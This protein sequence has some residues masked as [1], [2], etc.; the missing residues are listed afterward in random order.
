MQSQNIEYT[1]TFDRDFIENLF[2]GN[3]SVEVEAHLLYEHM[4][5]DLKSK[6]ANQEFLSSI[7]EKKLKVFEEKKE[8]EL[9]LVKNSQNAAI[10]E[11]Q[12]TI[13]LLT[14]K[15]NELTNRIAFLSEQFISTSTPNDNDNL[16]IEN[17][18]LKDKNKFLTNTCDLLKKSVND[19]AQEIYSL[20]GQSKEKQRTI[21]ELS[22]QVEDVRVAN[23][24]L[25]KLVD[26]YKK[27][28]AS[29]TAIYE[30]KIKTAESLVSDKLNTELVVL[31]Q[32]SKQAINEKDTQLKS[33]T[34]KYEKLTRQIVVYEKEIKATKA[35][36]A[37]VKSN[38]LES[39]S[40]LQKYKRNVLTLEDEV[41]TLRK[42]MRYLM[43]VM[44]SMRNKSYLSSEYGH[45][46]IYN[47]M[48][49]CTK[50]VEDETDKID[51]NY[52]LGLWVSRQGYACLVGV[53]RHIDENGER[54]LIMPTLTTNDQELDE[55]II[56]VISAIQ[57]PNEYSKQ[58]LDLL[59]TNTIAD[60]DKAMA[61]QHEKFEKMAVAGNALENNI[62]DD[63]DL[64]VSNHLI[65]PGIT[66]TNK[67]THS[68]KRKSKR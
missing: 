40:Y 57:P 59:M 14:D 7:Y 3:D 21:N 35:K 25:V 23:L 47:T 49:T 28:L 20:Y 10:A 61:Y 50:V 31:K 48:G 36:L 24:E 13:A 6:L 12:T 38:Q 55:N 18:S 43:F 4:I 41:F 17:K 52:P 68:K 54:Y 63:P 60:I 32:S 27:E 46:E 11:F 67:T 26:Q 65:Y 8:S 34:A 42:H 5:K 58:I 29:K 39:N 44:D 30:N 22:L 37:D 2:N 45:C 15:N 19:N 62:Y 64:K 51:S 33:V 9:A 53:S 56:N 16:A 1:A 66:A